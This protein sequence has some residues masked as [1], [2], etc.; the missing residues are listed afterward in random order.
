MGA[1]VNGGR[2]ISREKLKY[3]Q[4]DRHR[5]GLIGLG[6][7][8]CKAPGTLVRSPHPSPMH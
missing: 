1:L 7:T 5:R 6:M 8:R 2:G 4:E 3:K